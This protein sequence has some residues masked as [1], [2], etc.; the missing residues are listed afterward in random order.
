MIIGITACFPFNTLIDSSPGSSSSTSGQSISGDGAASTRRPVPTP[1][2]TVEIPILPTATPEPDLFSE[3]RL[4]AELAGFDI[5]DISGAY[6]AR[7]NANA[8]RVVT[9]IENL[10]TRDRQVSS[11]AFIRPGSFHVLKEDF[12]II[13]TEGQTYS[14]EKG[15][16]W[17]VSPR[18]D[19]SKLGQIFDPFLENETVESEIRR[20]RLNAKDL[21]YAG[22][23]SFD[24]KEVQV[25]TF[26]W[27][28]SNSES[29]RQ[30]EV[31][32]GDEDGL[33]YRQVEEYSLNGEQIRKLSSYRYG[34]DVEIDPP[35]P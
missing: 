32:L 25:L 23:E 35:F 21:I 17:F 18:E 3:D 19:T 6:R 1:L 9:V 34:S 30:V 8:L 29:E 16:N 7:S 31:W 24:G 20:L 12:E 4:S 5:D 28:N 14:K 26:S 11:I 2:P 33:L 27:K 10:T 13:I 22:R 15:A